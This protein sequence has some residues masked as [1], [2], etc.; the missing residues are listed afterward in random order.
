MS[1]T[2]RDRLTA[3]LTERKLSKRA[4]SLA[5]NLGPG[6]AHSILSE[7]KEPTIENLAKL[8][9]AN[10]IPLGRVIFGD[11]VSAERDELLA[12]FAEA[13]P[14]VRNSILELLRAHK[15]L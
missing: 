14:A 4:E 1:E 8:C 15:A 9:Q 6:Y 3:A 2:W 12:L 11:G 5:A 13:N 10:G 7:G